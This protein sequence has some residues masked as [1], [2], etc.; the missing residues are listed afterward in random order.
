MYPCI[1]DFRVR[2]QASVCTLRAQLWAYGEM[3]VGVTGDG[4]GGCTGRWWLVVGCDCTA[5]N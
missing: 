2:A 4:G 3:V 5:D 1:H